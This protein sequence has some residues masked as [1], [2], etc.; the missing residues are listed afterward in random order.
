MNDQNLC[1]W[2][3]LGC[4]QCVTV[5]HAPWWAS[6]RHRLC[7]PADGFSRKV[8]VG[9]PGQRIDSCFLLLGSVFTLESPHPPPLVHAAVP[10]ST[11]HRGDLLCPLLSL[12]FVIISPV[13]C[14]QTST[15]RREA[16]KLVV[17]CPQRTIVPTHH[18][19][20]VQVSGPLPDSNDLKCFPK[21]CFEV[22][23]HL[24]SLRWKP[25]YL[26]PFLPYSSIP[27]LS[28]KPFDK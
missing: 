20:C 6:G 11:S 13:A 3:A 23:C 27:S 7:V 22:S 10:V 28:H 15:L 14:P 17:S 19:T 9:L 16:S 5:T 2:S 24:P 18:V 8:L 4:R 21:L 25:T 1:H 12:F 26:F